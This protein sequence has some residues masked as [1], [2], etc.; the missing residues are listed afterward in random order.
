MSDGAEDKEPSSSSSIIGEM[1][2]EVG[3]RAGN[4]DARLI[5]KTLV[6]S[7]TGSKAGNEKSCS[8]SVH[9]L[10]CLVA[11]ILVKFQISH[12]FNPLRI[13]KIYPIDALAVVPI[14]YPFQPLTGAV[15]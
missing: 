13:R 9:Y 4:C 10:S 8:I 3:G 15:F 1:I 11:I 12:S 5:G 14:K 6:L 7:V 2:G